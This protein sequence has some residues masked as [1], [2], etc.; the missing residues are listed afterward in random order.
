MLVSS[1][2]FVDYFRTFTVT[3]N[4]SSF[5]FF[6]ASPAAQL[7]I[8]LGEAHVIRNAGGSAY[9]GDIPFL[10]V[11]ESSSTDYNCFFF[12]LAARRH[13]GAS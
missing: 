6:F 10:L 3:K 11:S 2:S 7:K 5:S 13:L 4:I 9:V 8:N 1:M 12:F